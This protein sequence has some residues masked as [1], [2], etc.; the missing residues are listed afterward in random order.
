MQNMDEPKTSDQI[1]INIWMQNPSQEPPASSKTPNKDL[2]D[3]GVLCTFKSKIE[4][5]NWDNGFTKGW[6]QYPNQDQ[7]AKPQSRTSSILQIPKLGLR[8]HRCSLHPQNQ[9]EE[10]KLGSWVYLRPLTISNF[11]RKFQDMSVI[12][13]SYLDFGTLQNYKLFWAKLIF[14]KIEFGSWATLSWLSWAKLIWVKTEFESWAS[15]SWLFWAKINWVKELS[16]SELFASELSYFE[17][18]PAELSLF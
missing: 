3:M 18:I 6:L 16:F 4:S 15:L 1:H 2:K 11:E 14:V 7:Y 5:Q 17:P 9:D 10:Q 13:T 12:K 8:G